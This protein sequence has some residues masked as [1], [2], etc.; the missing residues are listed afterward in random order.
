MKIQ[1]SRL[2]LQQLDHQ[3]DHL[4]A[5]RGHQAAALA[6]CFG[7]VAAIQQLGSYSK[8][9]AIAKHWLAGSSCLGCADQSGMNTQQAQSATLMLIDDPEGFYGVGTASLSDNSRQQ[10]SLAIQQAMHRAGKSHELPTLIWCLQAPGCEENVL[11]GIQDVVGNTVP[12]FGGST[13]DNDVSG[14][15]LQYDGSNLT[16]D[17]LIVAVFYPSTPM[18]SFF[19]SGYFTTGLGGIVTSVTDRRLYTIDHLPAAQVYNDWLQQA[20][21][22]PLTPGNILMQSTL[23]PL[24]REISQHNALPLHLLSHPA[25]MH[26]DNSLS[27]F[28]EVKT[29]EPLW[30]M[31]GDK[32]HLIARAGDVVKT[33]RQ[34]LKFQYNCDA[35]GAIIVYCAGC[36]LAVQ[37]NL[38][39]VQQA[40]KAELGDLPFVVTFTFGEQGC[41]LDGSSRH[42]NLMISAVLFGATHAN[43]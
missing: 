43:E 36:M 14:Q 39:E 1:T 7:S 27:L 24:G 19:S 25:V 10:A 41:F 30:L 21:A 16:T 18:S 28:S 42:G 32:A 13:A 3:L 22:T 37:D 15:W 40:I 31:Q 11:Q 4:N 20:G 26:D 23:F 5:A 35:A 2:D 33:A 8:S 12:I 34:N 38:A 9:Y 29:G 6:L 17:H